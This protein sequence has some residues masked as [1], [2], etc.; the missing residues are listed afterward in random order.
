M[1]RRLLFCV[2]ILYSD[3]YNGMLTLADEQ[4]EK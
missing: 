1:R 3:F 4:A 2:I